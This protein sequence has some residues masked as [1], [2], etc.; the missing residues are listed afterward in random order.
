M[1]TIALDN[2]TWDIGIDPD[3]KSIATKSDNNQIAQD[4][5]SSIRVWEGE[6]PMDIDR[7]IAYNEPEKLRG[8]L[9]FEMREQ[10]NL[11][12]GVAGSSVVFNKMND[13]ELDVTVYITT[14]EGETIEVR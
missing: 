3:T 13:R 7:G 6:L 11:I 10:A 8:V 2:K 12:E 4:V 5:C 14:D 1:I 9:N